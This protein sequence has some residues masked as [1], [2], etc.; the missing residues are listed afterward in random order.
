VP[1]VLA[2]TLTPLLEV[3]TDLTQRIHQYDATVRELIRTT[4]PVAQR[5]QQ[6]SGVGP[7]TALAHVL[8]IEDPRRF[9]KS[10]Q[11][12]AYFGLVRRLDESS[13][14]TRRSPRVGG[15][16]AKKR[17]VIAV[18]RKLAVLLHRLW[19]SERAYDPDY[20]HRAA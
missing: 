4:Y 9:A 5:L 15:R 17:A 10:C 19:I 2:A 13:T 7:L 8:L 12:G 1:P 16:N 18:A 20:R 11:V 3:I 6:P 14:L